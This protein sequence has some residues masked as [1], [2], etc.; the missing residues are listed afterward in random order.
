MVSYILSILNHVLF[1]HVCF[2]DNV[3]R[4]ILFFLKNRL[5]PLREQGL[6]FYA[7]ELTTYEIEVMQTHFI[8]YRVAK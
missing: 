8:L 4:K 6:N 7:K 1:N 5:F 2:P 3:H